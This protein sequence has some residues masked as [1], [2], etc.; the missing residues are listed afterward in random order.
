MTDRPTDKNAGVTSHFCRQQWVMGCLVFMLSLASFLQAASSRGVL[1]APPVNGGDEDCYE[2]LGFNIAAGLGF[3]YCPA[4]MPVVMG[5]SEPPPT[6]ACTAGCTPAEFSQTADRSPGFPLIVAAVYRVSP[7]N[8][9]AVRV[10][11]CVFCALAVA[12]AAAYFCREFSLATGLIAGG[13]CCLDPRFREFAG[14]FLTEN[15]ATL[16]LTLFAISFSRML[17]TGPVATVANPRSGARSYT[18]LNAGLC[19]LS[20]SALVCVRSFFVAWYPVLWIVVAVSLYRQCRRLQIPLVAA[21]KPLR[22]FCFASLVLTGPWWIRNCV[23]LDALMP[24]GTQGSIV[25]AEGFSDSAYANFGSWTPR[26]SEAIAAEMRQDPAL[27]KVTRIEFEREQAIRSVARASAWI[28]EHPQ[29]MPQLALWKLSRLWE[30]GSVRHAVLFA[31]LFAGM[32][33]TRAHPASRVLLLLLVLN[34]ITVM[35]THHTYERFMT[36]FRPMIHGMVA[37]GLIWIVTCVRRWRLMP[38]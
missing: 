21:L 24:T 36:P 25:I 6:A 11:N 10:I 2:R 3:G 19:G 34:S 31:S 38:R 29:L 5:M 35:A 33:A 37:C 13:F 32:F 22:V 7:L 17:T 1:H 30:F 4:D 9:F 12:L 20:F 26:M 27:Q 15:P 23:A 18:L 28:R 16:L 14:T 8:Y